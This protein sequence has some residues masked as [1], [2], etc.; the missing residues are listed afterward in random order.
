MNVVFYQR[1]S[2][3]AGF[4]FGNN[5]TQAIKKIDPIRGV[6]KYRFT[7]YSTN[8]DMMQSTWGLPAIASRHV[9]HRLRLRPALQPSRR[10]GRAMP[11]GLRR[12]GRASMRALSGM[13]STYQIT[14]IL[15]I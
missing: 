6:F 14:S 9:R 8:D 11:G 12:G 5:S 15:Q 4:C 7:L 3:A 13:A 1:P 10:G 2:I